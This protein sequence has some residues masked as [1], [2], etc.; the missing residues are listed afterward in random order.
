MQLENITEQIYSKEEKELAAEL[1]LTLLKNPRFQLWLNANYDVKILAK[2]RRMI[3]QLKN[4][5]LIYK[6]PFSK[7]ISI[8]PRKLKKLDLMQYY[9]EDLKMWFKK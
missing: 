9:L 2:P 6:A 8:K 3:P 1:L 5:I 7:E 4:D